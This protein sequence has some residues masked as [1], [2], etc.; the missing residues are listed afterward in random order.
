MDIALSDLLT[1]P[2]CGPTH[3]LIL[4]PEEVRDRRVVS[5]VLGCPN[6]RERYRVE[7][8]VADLRGGSE[9]GEDAG[10]AVAEGGELTTG[11]G[12]AAL[13]LAA[14]LGLSEGGGMVLIAGPSAVLAP[15]VAELAPGTSMITSAEAESL[16]GE[17]GSP[18]EAESAGGGVSRL[19]L[20]RLL[21]LRSGSLRGVALTGVYAERVEEGA[22]LL[23]PAGRLVLDPA[24]ADAGI[25][26]ESAGL[27]SLVSEGG[28][29]VAG[30][31][32]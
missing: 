12:E 4:L 15:G 11:D 26:L 2:R 31:H 23:A 22:R 19:R 29:V 14:L 13:R 27:R 32:R 8:A 9:E 20:G 18:P 21:P 10:G 25:R 6:C 24:P 16:P 5:G 28:V 3:G 30:R 17:T 7:G 1:C